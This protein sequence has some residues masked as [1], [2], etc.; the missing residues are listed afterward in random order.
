[1]KITI[2]TLFP[3]IFEGF[4]NSSIPLIAKNK[5]LLD[6]NI[7]N[8]RDFT[9][10]KHHKCDD[11]PYG[12]GPGMVLKPEPLFKAF[13]TINTN[14]K[15]VIY[16]TP[17]GKVFKQEIAE[18]LAKEEE[19]IFIAGHYEGLDQRVIDTFVTDE[20]SIGD[21]VLSSGE[22][23]TLVIIDAI[24]RLIEGVITKESLEEESF[25]DGLLEYPLYTRPYEY[26]GL[27]VPS[28]LVSGDHKKIYEWRLSKR[29]EKTK[30]NRIDLYRKF[31][32]KENKEKG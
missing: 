13:N 25:V 10:D 18:E 26:E 3:E 16:P 8:F 7:V 30:R 22:T 19:L 24:Y 32:K 28:V 9:E 12:G 14:H 5:G 1:M 20:L 11:E 15:R 2:L 31:K 23:A 27:T 17:S 29:L 4:F 21:Y 6:V